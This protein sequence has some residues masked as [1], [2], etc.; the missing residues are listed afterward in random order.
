MVIF[1]NVMIF[2]CMC[3]CSFISLIDISTS[4]LFPEFQIDISSCLSFS[5]K[6]LIH[7]SNLRAQNGNPHLQSFPFQ[8]I[9]T[10]SFQLFSL[11]SLGSL[12]TPFCHNPY[13]VCQEILLALSSKYI[14]NL[15][16]LHHFYYHN[17]ISHYHPYLHKV[18]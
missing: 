15:A 7:I 2:K 4:D 16:I 9:V 12:L 14:Q 10:S 6:C 18:H 8:L 13:S 11:K 1:S 3:M 17:D 5:L